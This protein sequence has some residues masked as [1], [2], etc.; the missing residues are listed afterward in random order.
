MAPG[1]G[2]FLGQWLKKSGKILHR[3][4]LEITGFVFLGLAAHGTFSTLREWRA[5]ADGGPVWKLIAAMFFLILMASFGIYSF[6]RA[7]RIQ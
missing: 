2:Q 5:Y 6:L 4:W 1:I 7:R 3:L